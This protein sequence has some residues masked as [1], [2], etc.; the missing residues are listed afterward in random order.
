MEAGTQPDG[1]LPIFVSSV[2]EFGLPIGKWETGKLT[3]GNGK[4]QGCA[5][6]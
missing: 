4:P 2:N 1:I 3:D 6:P 5:V